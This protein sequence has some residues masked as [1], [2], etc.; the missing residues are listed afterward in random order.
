MRPTVDAVLKTYWIAEERG[1]K[2]LMPPVLQHYE[3]AYGSPE[4]C[5]G[6]LAKEE[7]MVA[8]ADARYKSGT[9]LGF[10]EVFKLNPDFGL[11]RDLAS[12]TF[13]PHH[14]DLFRWMNWKADEYRR[15]MELY[16]NS[17]NPPPEGGKF[18]IGSGYRAGTPKFDVQE[19][20]DRAFL[21]LSDGLRSAASAV[22]GQIAAKTG[23]EKGQYAC[24]Q[25]RNGDG[26][27]TLDSDTVAWVKDLV[28]DDLPLYL[29]SAHSSTSSRQAASNVCS[30]SG[31][32]ASDET[33]PAGLWVDNRKRLFLEM[34]V[35]AMAAVT[36]LPNQGRVIKHGS[37]SD[38]GRKAGVGSTLQAAVQRMSQMPLLHRPTGFPKSATAHAQ[39]LTDFLECGAMSDELC[40]GDESFEGE[41]DAVVD[42]LY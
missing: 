9:H 15:Y 11:Q 25:I 35:C 33:L 37:I 40:G 30:T 10:N 5:H 34:A 26:A 6:H 28:D 17:T 12:L 18:T 21:D 23:G 13:L 32:V 31:C 1:C 36:Y 14:C 22:Q 20:F 41:E 7:A 8:A 24:L 3:L 42:E 2:L 19:Y 39:A 16:M 29:M 38:A 27:T 4:E